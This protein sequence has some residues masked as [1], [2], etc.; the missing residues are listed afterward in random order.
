M[1]AIARKTEEVGLDVFREYAGD[2]QR[3]LVIVSGGLC[4]PSSSRLLTDRIDAAVSGELASAGVV[5]TSSVIELRPLVLPEG[6]LSGRPV[7]IGATSG[8]ERHSLVLEHA[9]RRMFSHLHA[10]VSPTG[11]MLPPTTSARSTV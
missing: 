3:Q 6:T 7:L 2:Y 4:E 5:D 8:T 9:L 1:A 11:S 10:I